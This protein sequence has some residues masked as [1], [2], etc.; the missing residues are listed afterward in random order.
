MPIHTNHS[1]RRL[2]PRLRQ[3][4]FDLSIVHVTEIAP[5]VAL[6][7]APVGLS[8]SQRRPRSLASANSDGEGE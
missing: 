6:L 8:G 3:V 7:E 2:E 1:Q 4:T 5:L